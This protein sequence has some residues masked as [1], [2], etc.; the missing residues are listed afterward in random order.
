M[1]ICPKCGAPF[2]Y[3]E[4][5]VCEGRDIT[6]LWSLASVAI[7]VLI[8]APIGGRAGLLYANSL[9]ADA[10]G[11]PDASNLC[12][13][14]LTPSI[15]LYV[16]TGAMMGASIVALAVGVIVALRLRAQ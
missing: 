15:P 12:G 3:S 16:I 14:P 8:G 4:I 2:S 9:I 7:G 6:K 11:K 10:C 1:A 13:L 5:H